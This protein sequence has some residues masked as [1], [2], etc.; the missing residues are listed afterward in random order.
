MFPKVFKNRWA[1]CY[2]VSLLLSRVK[3]T[4]L[5]NIHNDKDDKVK[6]CS[7]RNFTIKNQERRIH[8]RV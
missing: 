5:E 7:Q 1:A 3:S 6:M 2:V 8:K 4:I